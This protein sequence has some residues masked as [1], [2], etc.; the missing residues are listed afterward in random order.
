MKYFDIKRTSDFR[1]HAFLKIYLKDL[2]ALLVFKDGS[3]VVL[4]CLETIT[5]LFLL[6]FVSLF[7]GLSYFLEP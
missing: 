5:C 7:S 6:S 3:T 1:S 2:L 4:S